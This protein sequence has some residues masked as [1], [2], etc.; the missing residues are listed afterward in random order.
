[1]T[2]FDDNEN[3]AILRLWDMRYDTMAIALK[4]KLKEAIVYNKL[5]H[6]RTLRLCARRWGITQ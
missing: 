6:L 2:S 3:A 4:L 1:L 5:I